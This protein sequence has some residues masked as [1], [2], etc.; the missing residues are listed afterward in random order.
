MFL[1]YR[2]AQH[3]NW[4]RL[5]CDRWC[6]LTCANKK[7][8]YL[9]GNAAREAVS[10][11]Q[12][13]VGRILQRGIVLTFPHHECCMWQHTAVHP[14]ANQTNSVNICGFMYE[15]WYQRFSELLFIFYYGSDYANSISCNF[16]HP[17]FCICKY[18]VCSI[19]FLSILNKVNTCFNV[20]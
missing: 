9:T 20:L 10:A 11:Q 13:N 2:W 8:S 7:I 12:S 19:K 6:I 4:L 1:H 5:D 3:K 16:R 14:I 18:T 17:W 15:F